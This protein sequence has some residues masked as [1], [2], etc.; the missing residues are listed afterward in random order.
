MWRSYQIVQKWNQTV[1]IEL[2]LK[3]ISMENI[4]ITPTYEIQTIYLGRMV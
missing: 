2:G 4:F 3:S 1:G